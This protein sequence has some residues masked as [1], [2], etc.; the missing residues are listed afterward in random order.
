MAPDYPHDD[1]IETAPPVDASYGHTHESD[2]EK[3]VLSNGGEGPT[4][5]RLKGYH[6]TW[7]GLCGGIGT[8]LFIGAG[9]AYAT[10]GPAGLLLAYLVVGAVLWSVMQSISELAT[11]VCLTIID[12][13]KNTDFASYLP[14][15]HFLT[16]QLA[17]SILQSVSPL[18]SHTATA[19]PS[20]SQQNVRHP[21]F[22]SVTGQTSLQQLSSPSV[23]FSSSGST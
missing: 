19:T 12:G 6:I 20:P 22:W 3:P 7:I 15:V 17:L 13:M 8:G 18:Q 11:L 10:S 16:G 21:Q 4:Q 1:A 23:L 5:R 2:D 9:S 14:L